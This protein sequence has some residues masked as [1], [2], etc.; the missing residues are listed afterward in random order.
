[1]RAFALCSSVVAL[2][3]ITAAA[4]ADWCSG[5]RELAMEMDLRGVTYIEVRAVAG[6]LDIRGVNAPG[7]LLATG[8]ACTQRRYRDRI[9]EIRIVEE[10]DG[11]T[12]RIIAVVP[13]A[14][15]INSSLIGAL[16][17]TLKVP[18]D[19][20]L[21]VFDSSGDIL[22]ENVGPLTVTDSS[23]DMRLR[24]INGDLRI[25]MDSSGDIDIRNAGNVQIDVDSSGDVDIREA[26]SVAIDKDSSGDIDA[27][28]IAADVY[29]G[30]DS[31]G[32]I[33]V[34]NVGGNLTVGRDGSGDIRHRRVA[35][36]VTVPRNKRDQD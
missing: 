4:D 14:G 6:D 22:I 30:T 36:T 9:S 28:D 25:D 29:I 16:D 31:S 18:N 10:R 1:M 17:L 23:G 26:L 32:D 21:S 3:A 19:V 34:R 11:G 12:L 20:P 35:G 33:E 13:E 5:A 15:R 8:E 2:F 27:Q 7:Q 24:K